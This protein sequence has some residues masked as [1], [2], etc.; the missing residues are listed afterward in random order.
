MNCPGCNARCD[1]E[2]NFYFCR[3]CGAEE[4]LNTTGIGHM[5]IKAGKVIAIPE[6]NEESL[7]RAKEAYPTGE[8]DKH[9]SKPR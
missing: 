8:W 9:N 3:A 1:L 6:A 2:K 5:W 4:R 7:K